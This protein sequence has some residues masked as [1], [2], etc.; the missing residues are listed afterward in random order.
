MTPPSPPNQSHPSPTKNVIREARGNISP[1]KNHAVGHEGS[2]SYIWKPETCRFRN[3]LRPIPSTPRLSTAMGPGL[4]VGP[5]MASLWAPEWSCRSQSHTGP[6]SSQ[7]AGVAVE[8]LECGWSAPRCVVSVKS[9]PISKTSFKR[10]AT[11][12]ISIS[13]IC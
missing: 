13:T 5:L 12:L 8:P 1:Q 3:L 7:S 4:E 11:S 9:R 2:N 6:Y 10:T